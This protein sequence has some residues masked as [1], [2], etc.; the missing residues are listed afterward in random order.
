MYRGE[1]G[2]ALKDFT[3]DE[4]LAFGGLIRALIMA[5]GQVCDD[6]HRALARLA[7]DLGVDT[8]W[9]YIDQAAEQLSGPEALENAIDKVK[10]PA[11]QE[12]I[13]VTLYELAMSS[14]ILPSEAAILDRLTELWDVGVTPISEA[15][16][17]T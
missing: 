7:K 17:P 12:L 14:S 9:T 16:P 10:R 13:F 3:T 5:D 6:E 15:P 8:F 1:A 4:I 11:V 2:A